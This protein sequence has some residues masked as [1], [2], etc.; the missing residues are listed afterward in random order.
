LN[1]HPRPAGAGS[2]PP[3]TSQWV[4]SLPVL[5]G[6]WYCC[7]GALWAPLL[8][9][10]GYRPY[11]LEYLALG[12]MT[13]VPALLAAGASR[14]SSALAALLAALTLFLFMDL[15]VIDVIDALIGVIDLGLLAIPCWLLRRRIITVLGAGG[16]AFTLSVALTAQPLEPIDW[17]AVPAARVDSRLPPVI[18]LIL[19]E[20]CGTD[21]F[22]PEVM[23]DDERRTARQAYVDRGFTVWSG[24]RSTA[25]NTRSSLTAMM[26][27]ESATPDRLLTRHSGEFESALTKN[28]YFE[29]MLHAGYRIRV[30]QSSFLNFCAPGMTGA[31]ECRAYPHNSAGV[32]R[33]LDLELTERLRLLAGILDWSIRHQYD[34]VAYR[35]LLNTDLGARIEHWRATDARSRLQPL[36]AQRQLARVTADLASVG[37]GDLYV[38]HLLVPHHPYVFDRDCHVLPIEQWV[39]LNVPSP[40]T[41]ASIR[42][43]RYESYKAQVICTNQMITALLD[44]IAGHDSLQNAIIVLHGDHGSRIGPPIYSRI[45]PGYEPSE[46]EKDFRSAFFVTKVPGRAPGTRVVEDVPLPDAF[47]SIMGPV[48]AG[49]H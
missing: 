26:N 43:E 7:I 45:G 11:D 15:Y 8:L 16:L 23:S 40:V 34:T 36:V 22:P 18:H 35:E 37:P 25:I 29:R 20:H 24:V 21:C 2:Q 33:F 38:A 17:S 12:G 10:L 27:P 44:N 31:I 9:L 47:W 42:I 32:L 19:D 14:S 1:Q 48:A 30:L 13:V 28:S 4:D 3:A 41:S 5:A 49:Q 6:A 39:D 46:H